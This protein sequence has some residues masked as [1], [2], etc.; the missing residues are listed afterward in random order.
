MAVD[1]TKVDSEEQVR[2]SDKEILSQVKIW[3]TIDFKRNQALQGAQGVII[4]D[5]S[6]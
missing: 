4:N 6:R 5:G 3:V 2:Y 1:P